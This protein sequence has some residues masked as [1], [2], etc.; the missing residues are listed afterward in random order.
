M[1]QLFQ[2]YKYTNS[3]ILQQFILYSQ[4]TFLTAQKRMFIC[5]VQLSQ[6]LLITNQK[7]EDS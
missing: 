5:K 6:S 4:Q 3:G 7:K 2:S 1:V